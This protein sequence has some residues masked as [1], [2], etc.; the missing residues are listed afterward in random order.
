MRKLAAKILFVFLLVGVSLSA[1][2]AS[3]QEGDVSYQQVHI[4]FTGNTDGLLEPCG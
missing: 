1:L 3:E 4:L 2:S